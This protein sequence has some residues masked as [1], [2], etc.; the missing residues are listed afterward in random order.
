VKE[1]AYN[2]QS[3][4]IVPTCNSPLIES[5][6]LD[7]MSTRVDI[8][9]GTNTAFASPELLEEYDSVKETHR[10]KIYLGRI[11]GASNLFLHCISL[12]ESEFLSSI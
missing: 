1:K 8:C 11:E 12:G 9:L 7:Q 5:D 10:S 6:N 2:I 4:S 3:P